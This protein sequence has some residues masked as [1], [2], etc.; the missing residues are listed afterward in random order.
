V[1]RCRHRWEEVRRYFVRPKSLTEA[2]NVPPDLAREWTQGVT[3]VELRCA[4]CGDV[5]G[6]RLPGDAT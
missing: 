5:Q 4:E 3:V 6:R 2:E 1:K